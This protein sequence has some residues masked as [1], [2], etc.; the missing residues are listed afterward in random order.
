M[1]VSK[2]RQ[3]ACCHRGQSKAS[4]QST[5]QHSFGICIY[6]KKCEH[7]V[8]APLSKKAPDRHA[9]Q[10]VGLVH[11]A[12]VDGQAKEKCNITKHACHTL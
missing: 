5:V 2:N 11:D 6:T 9:V 8:Q 12:Q 10:V 7:P 4:F 1:V 3:G